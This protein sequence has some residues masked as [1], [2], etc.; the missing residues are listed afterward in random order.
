M[1]INE[2]HVFPFVDF[3]TE[4]ISKILNKL[5]VSTIPRFGMMTPQHMIEHLIEVI[6]FDQGEFPKEL[7]IPEELIP[8]AQ[9]WLSSPNKIKPQSVDFPYRQPGQLAELKYADLPKS[10]DE[11]LKRVQKLI[12]TSI[13][14]PNTLRFHPRFGDLNAQNMI[15]FQRKHFTYHFE[16]FGLI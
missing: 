13:E 11:L 1:T 5:T 6:D 8:K 10:K 4:E 2:T 15:L 9:A 3:S 16:Q 12:E 7:L 14:N